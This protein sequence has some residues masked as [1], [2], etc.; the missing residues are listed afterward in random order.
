LLIYFNDYNFL[1]TNQ[2]P[3]FHPGTAPV[4]C[5]QLFSSVGYIV[6]KTHV[7]H[8]NQNTGNTL[9]CAFVVG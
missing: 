7:L 2:F 4:P 6:N 8:L 1:T 5:K 3:I 9:S